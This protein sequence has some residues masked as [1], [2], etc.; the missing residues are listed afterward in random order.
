MEYIK[1]WYVL[2]CVM[3]YGM[4]C[5][6]CRGISC[7]IL[8]NGMYDGMTCICGMGYMKCIGA[9]MVVWHMLYYD[10]WNALWLNASWYVEHIVVCGMHC[11]RIC[12]MAWKGIGD[13]NALR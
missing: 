5:G 8:W 2:H 12:I 3:H 9:C 6:I 10:L 1:V 11:D 13:K 4:T 7:T